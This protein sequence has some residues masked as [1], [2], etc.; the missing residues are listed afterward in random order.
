MAERERTC[1]ERLEEDGFF[2]FRRARPTGALPHCLGRVSRTA[3]PG[4]DGR[5]LHL[6]VQKFFSGEATETWARSVRA[7]VSGDRAAASAAALAAAEAADAGK[8]NRR[9]AYFMLAL[10]GNVDAA[11]AQADRLFTSE[12][13]HRRRRPIHR[14]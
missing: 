11:L 3:G 6:V 12:W 14:W 13:L 9:D 8:F 2:L 1:S 4:R 5:H 10:V 7:R